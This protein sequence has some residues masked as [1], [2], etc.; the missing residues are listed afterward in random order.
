MNVINFLRKNSFTLFWWI[1]DDF[2]KN[3]II[4]IKI[5]FYILQ[6]KRK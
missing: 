5:N 1:F 4:L 6:K 3:K 2:Y